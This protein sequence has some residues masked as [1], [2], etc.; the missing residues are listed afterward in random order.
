MAVL[1]SSTSLPF[2]APNQILRANDLNNLVNILEQQNRLSRVFSIGIGIISGFSVE[3]E[4]E[5][6]PPAGEVAKVQRIILSAGLGIS[7]D[8][9]LFQLEECILEYVAKVT[10][11][12]NLFRAVDREDL[13]YDNT[14]DPVNVCELKTEDEL[15]P[16][17]DFTP[18]SEKLYEE[19]CG[20]KVLL[21]VW[22]KDTVSRK[23]CFN[24]C[25]EQGADQFFRI[26]KLLL[27]KET[28][29]TIVGR[30]E[31]AGQG[32]ST[33]IE[34][35]EVP[36]IRR[37]GYWENQNGFNLCEIENWYSFYKS[38]WDQSQQAIPNIVKAYEDA[39]ENFG[40]KVEG[41]QEDAFDGLEGN[42]SD[43]QESY[44]DPDNDS[45]PDLSDVQ[46][47]Y[48]YFKDLVLAY[49]EFE[50]VANG[51]TI[52]GTEGQS[53]DLSQFPGHIALGLITIP[54]QGE[55]IPAFF[56]D[57]CRSV[58]QFADYSSEN[59]ER[60]E[61]AKC[62]YK[63]M[64]N[65]TRTTTNL[66]LPPAQ[67]PELNEIKL[68]PSFKDRLLSQR[69]I[70]FYYQLVQVRR[71]WNPALE[72]RSRFTRIPSYESGSQIPP[73]DVHLHYDLDQHNFFRIEGHVGETLDKVKGRIDSLRKGLN[74]P[75]DIQCVFIGPSLLDLSQEK[76]MYFEDLERLFLKTKNDLICKLLELQ[77]DRETKINVNEIQPL[78]EFLEMKSMEQL[79]AFHRSFGTFT[80]LYAAV[81]PAGSALEEC[82]RETLEQLK[83]AY[84][85]RY[86]KIEKSLSFPGFAE[87]HP[88]MEHRAGVQKGGTFILVYVFR[89]NSLAKERIKIAL[90][91]EELEYINQL[92]GNFDDLNEGEI[93]KA[94]LENE[95]EDSDI[96]SLLREN[97][98]RRVVGDFCL[99]YVC[100]SKTPSIKYAIEAIRVSISVVPASLCEDDDPVPIRVFPE[101]GEFANPGEYVQGDETNGYRFDPG[102]SDLEFDENGIASVT[103]TYIVAGQ[104]AST[105]LR[106]YQKP[107]AKFELTKESFFDM[108]PNN[109]SNPCC[110]LG[111]TF[112]LENQ[113]ENAEIFEWELPDGN[114]I[115]TETPEE[116]TI[117]FSHGLVSNKVRL[118]ARREIPGV[119]PPDSAEETVELCPE[120]VN[121]IAEFRDGN[122]VEIKEN[123]LAL[124]LGDTRGDVF[125][126]PDPTG[127]KFTVLRDGQTVDGFI[128]YQPT[129]PPNCVDSKY[130]I[131][132]SQIE[133]PGT[134]QLE[135]RFVGCGEEPFILTVNITEAKIEIEPKEFCSDD[136][137]IN[138][139]VPNNDVESLDQSHPAISVVNGNPQ[140]EPSQ[141][142]QD[143]DAPLEVVKIVYKSP[144]GN[145]ISE[146]VTVYNAA[147]AD[148]TVEEKTAQYTG[149]GQECKFSG[150]VVR[151]KNTSSEFATIEWEE[152]ENAE[153]IEGGK[154]DDE[155][156]LRVRIGEGD[157]GT[158]LLNARNPEDTNSLCHQGSKT[159]DLCPASVEFSFSDNDGKD[160]GRLINGILTI[161]VDLSQN[162]DFAIQIAPD[163][164]SGSI[165][166]TQKLFF[167]NDSSGNIDII[168]AGLLRLL[169]GESCSELRYSL[170]LGEGLSA[171]IVSIEFE[172]KYTLPECGVDENFRIIINN[173]SDFTGGGET[174]DPGFVVA[175]P[176]ERSAAPPPDAIALLNRRQ[177]V[178]RSIIDE[179][180]EDASMAK[181]KAFR[182]AKVFLPFRGPE[183]KLNER[184]DEV[185]SALY[186]GG[187]RAKDERRE[188]YVQLITAVAE[189][190]F[191]KLVA[192][193]EDELSDAARETIKTQVEKLKKMDMDLGALRRDWQRNDLKK[194]MP[195]KAID[196][197]YRL[198]K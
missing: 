43:I 183:A 83:N 169:P 85:E 22:Y 59:F 103:L 185:I 130:L 68:T 160:L 117:L 168:Q 109:D 163:P 195:K 49:W 73:F 175:S 119:C 74:V 121:F 48:D 132:L 154:E 39:Q 24:D 57:D 29:L 5:P 174:D 6:N 189:S 90:E 64:V 138:F 9:Y 166:G 184:F 173:L 62:L 196:Q 40:K 34:L 190:Y 45:L 167:T 72:K 51:L 78:L 105:T 148:F 100:C 76:E 146:E 16:G 54:C 179:Q 165:S 106:V 75:F 128:T 143:S 108:D 17:E 180:E 35:N 188:Q 97:Y 118:T 158:I 116:L 197:I 127:G 8:G 122:S 153:Y 178:Y 152:P 86:K 15:L 181:T 46:Y 155:V 150:Y 110:L 21:L 25:E 41:L 61:Y 159:L 104:E 99:P 198:L 28:Y 88:G 71:C 87:L 176:Q 137:A 131:N 162:P 4:L 113:S 177:S 93:I 60:L 50:S 13:R 114:S 19:C 77:Q 98:D 31:E 38:F 23:A 124:S 53:L 63:R 171:G 156:T 95:K 142:I 79:G 33:T 111:Y 191:D 14:I 194:V 133:E 10:V 47:L 91:N 192:E 141:A 12:E 145:E 107:S 42:L 55:Q 170:S 129:Q 149:E 65:L 58:A 1:N 81:F 80:E 37:F 101:G 193:T 27:D 56:S 82:C 135:Y 157:S 164:T 67:F 96:L 52:V 151:L 2:F 147:V 36:Y 11:S 172:L 69:A 3:V 123:T 136:D 44:P 112:K 30:D 140:F 120:E 126:L 20:E 186:N 84:E 187:V 125:L 94:I 7:S 66:K 89:L 32:S 144:D 102:A 134:Y 92:E 18:V 115:E 139:R 70:P 161:N 182:L 26:R